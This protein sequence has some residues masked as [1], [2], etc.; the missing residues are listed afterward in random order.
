MRILFI[1]YAVHGTLGQTYGT[2]LAL[3]AYR[4]I[5]RTSIVLLPVMLAGTIGLTTMFGTRGAAWSTCAAYALI[6]VWWALR[7]RR[8][9]R[10][11]PFDEHYLRALA[12]ATI[13]L[14]VAVLISRLG[15]E[16]PPV[17]SAVTIIFGAAV[18]W[19]IALLVA[20]GL[21]PDERAQAVRLLQRL[22]LARRA[23]Y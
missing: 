15:H 17:G 9:L 20:G 3:G 1:G 8:R 2:L 22:N 21:N 12:A 16:L 5:W 11:G 19:L 4:D 10:T 18:A 23:G 7:V 6:G 13:S 14:L